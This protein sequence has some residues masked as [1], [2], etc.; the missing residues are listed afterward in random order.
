MTLLGHDVRLYSRW[1]RDFEAINSTGGIEL[2]G[3]VEGRAAKPLLTTDIERAVRGADTVIVAAPAFA[4]AYLSQQLAALL[5][6]EQLVVFQ[7]SVLG[8]SLELA[9]HLRRLGVLPA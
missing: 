6:P 4:H 9:R 2:S 1:E 8:S 7:P 5:E 3:D